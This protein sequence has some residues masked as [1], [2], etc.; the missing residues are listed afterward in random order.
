MKLSGASFTSTLPTAVGVAGKRY[1]FI[2]AGTSLTQVYTLATTSAQTIG[3]V[4]SGAYAL[5]TNGE[6]LEIESDGAN[7]IIVNHRAVT[8]WVDAGTISLSATSAYVFTVTAANATQGTTYTNNGFTYMV[9]TTISGTTTLTCSGTGT[10]ASSGTLTKTGAGAGDSTITF[11]SRTITGQPILGTT[12][13][14]SLQWMR[15]GQHAILRY[16]INQTAAGTAGSGDYVLYLVSGMPVINTTLFPQYLVGPGTTL[17]NNAPAFPSFVPSSGNGNINN[18][19]SIM[20][21]TGSVYGTNSFRFTGGAG[22]VTNFGSSNLQLSGTQIGLNV[23][24]TVP[25]T[26]FQP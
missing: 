18:T 26:G 20:G 24:V 11:S 8:D 19:T 4:A 15:Q 5:Y 21:I 23:T 14:N 16:I 3:G 22:G 6:I 10:P 9:S 2:H 17:V 1:K 13:T 7:W 25:I 12:S